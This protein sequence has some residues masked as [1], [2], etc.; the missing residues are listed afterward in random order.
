MTIPKG[1]FNFNF[2][3]CL[4]VKQY[5]GHVFQMIYFF[6]AKDYPIMLMQPLQTKT[7]AIISDDARQQFRKFCY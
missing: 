1:V 2:K 4:I 3:V 7:Y 5:T 6:V